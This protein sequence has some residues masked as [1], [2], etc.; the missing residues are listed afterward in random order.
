MSKKSDY[1]FYPETQQV[2]FGYLVDIAIP[3][4]ERIYILVDRI[5]CDRCK[6]HS[7]QR[8][9]Q[10]YL[11]NIAQFH[12]Q[13]HIWCNTLTRIQSFKLQVR[14]K[15][16]DDGNHQSDGDI[17]T[18]DEHEVI[19]HY[20]ADWEFRPRDDGKTLQRDLRIVWSRKV[21]HWS[22]EG[23]LGNLTEHPYQC[24]RVLR[25]G[26]LW[27]Q[28][29]YQ[30][31]EPLADVVFEDGQIGGLAERSQMMGNWNATIK[32]LQSHMEPSGARITFLD[33]DGEEPQ[34]ECLSHARDVLREAGLRLKGDGI[35]IIQGDEVEVDEKKDDGSR[36][37]DGDEER[38]IE[39]GEF[40]EAFD[41][42]SYPSD[43]I[44][45]TSNHPGEEEVD[46]DGPGDASGSARDSDDL[47]EEDGDVDKDEE[48]GSEESLIGIKRG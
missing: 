12:K 23:P 46:D 36:E 6:L 41:E 19:Y 1:L 18:R 34:L 4:L 30:N 40:D 20:C 32:A 15:N 3:S 25:Q 21:K 11:P 10:C 31:K 42:A 22:T 37:S 13:I 47:D 16:H 9:D 26:E 48:T 28:G 35:N 7:D 29:A 5:V 39:S 45:E 24:Q 33:S 38:S 2:S 17:P 43:E 8:L 14:L 44:S 27:E